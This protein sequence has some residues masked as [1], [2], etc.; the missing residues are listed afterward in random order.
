MKHTVYL[1][2]AFDVAPEDEAMVTDQLLALVDGEVVN[3]QTEDEALA[4]A[5]EDYPSVEAFMQE[6]TNRERPYRVH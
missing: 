3:R 4:D 5:A 1:T 2:L 6:L